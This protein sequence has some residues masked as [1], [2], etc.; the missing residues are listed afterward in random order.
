MQFRLFACHPLFGNNRAY[1]VLSES[2]ITIGNVMGIRLSGYINYCCKSNSQTKQLCQHNIWTIRTSKTCV[3]FVTT[4]HSTQ[5]QPHQV[6]TP[7]RTNLL[8]AWTD[9]YYTSTSLP[10]Y[11]RTTQQF[12]KAIE[13]NI[14]W[15]AVEEIWMHP[16]TGQSWLFDKHTAKQSTCLLWR[17]NNI[18]FG[19]VS[20]WIIC[21]LRTID[22]DTT[23]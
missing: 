18:C 5:S 15:L 16:P 21:M 3:E 6:L 20:S 4:Q 8:F 2:V 11:W 19:W 7:C 13:H 9:T 10:R 17:N 12:K 23:R 22:S 1:E 14:L